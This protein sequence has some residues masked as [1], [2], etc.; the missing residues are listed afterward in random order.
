M[1][2]LN[3]LKARLSGDQKSELILEKGEEELH[4]LNLKKAMDAHAAWNSRLK[5]VLDGT[6]TESL[7]V[8]EISQDC[9]CHLGK[10]IYGPAKKSHSAYEEYE[11]LRKT[12]AEFHLCAGEILMKH[13]AGNDDAADKLLNTKFRSLSNKIQLELVILFSKA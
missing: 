9:N 11:I 6:S 5:S 7:N 12:H 1:G 2:M 8:G 4:G 10:W 3:W 13:Q